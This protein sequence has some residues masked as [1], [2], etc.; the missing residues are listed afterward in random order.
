MNTEKIDLI[1][2]VF[3]KT[4]YLKTI[5]TEFS[6]L[7]TTTI[8]EDQDNE[9]TVEQFFQTYNDIFYDIPA[10]GEINS[11]QFL[12]RTSADYINFE[13]VNEEIAAL[14]AEI[15]QLRQ[16]LLNAQI[17]N[18]SNEAA[19]TGDEATISQI[20]VLQRQLDQA[21]QDVINTNTNISNQP[22]TSTSR[23]QNQ[24][25]P[26]E[27][28][29]TFSGQNGQG[30]SATTSTTGGGGGGGNRTFARDSINED[31]ENEA[32]MGAMTGVGRSNAQNTGY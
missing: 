21:N 25:P 4:E 23:N 7:G 30:S 14:R 3:N 16:D 18:I 13:E 12:I 24:N 19:R 29:N 27:S 28:A 11:H 22:T 2:E 6:E 31:R 17:Q 10:L 9:T 32:A 5:N 1:K 26:N 15:A 20:E 8:T